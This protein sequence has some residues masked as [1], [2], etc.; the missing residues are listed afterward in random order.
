MRVQRACDIGK[1]NKLDPA[2]RRWVL[3]F[4]AVFGLAGLVG[5]FYVGFGFVT[6][7]AALNAPLM[8]KLFL[9]TFVAISCAAAGMIF[10]AFIGSTIYRFIEKPKRNPS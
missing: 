9:N 10:G 8:E 4:A 2:L 6:G 3:S 5:G 1:K 7:D